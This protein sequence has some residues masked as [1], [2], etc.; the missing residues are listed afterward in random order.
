MKRA[1]LMNEQYMQ[2]N[3]VEIPPFTLKSSF[4]GQSIQKR[5]N[6]QSDL[7][8]NDKIPT[9]YESSDAPMP[10]TIATL[11]SFRS[12]TIRKQVL[13][14]L[15][16]GCF[17]DQRQT[18][19]TQTSTDSYEFSPTSKCEWPRR[20]YASTLWL[21]LVNSNPDVTLQRNQ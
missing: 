7:A 9:K 4:A 14:T 1:T 5:L 20:L 16:R 3:P 13:V 21:R 19:T 8:F 15:T 12:H 17:S 18:G 10:I 2:S 11:L 6:S